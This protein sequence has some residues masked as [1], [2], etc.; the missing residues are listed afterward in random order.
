MLLYLEAKVMEVDGI[1]FS[2]LGNKPTIFVKPKIHSMQLKVD[3]IKRKIHMYIYIYCIYV[4]TPPLKTNC[5][6]IWNRIHPKSMET[7]GTVTE[8]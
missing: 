4:N 7:H 5:H 8:S 6:R 3:D 2:I 1:W